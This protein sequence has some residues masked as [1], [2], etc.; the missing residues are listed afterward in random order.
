MFKFCTECREFIVCKA[1]AEAY[2]EEQKNAT[3]GTSI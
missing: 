3:T 2:L 1:E